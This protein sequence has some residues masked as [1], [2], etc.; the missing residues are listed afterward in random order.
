VVVVNISKGQPAKAV[1]GKWNYTKLR[2]SPAT[3]KITDENTGIE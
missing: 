1:M 2:L 3:E